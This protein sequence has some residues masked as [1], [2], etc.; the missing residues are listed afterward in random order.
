MSKVWENFASDF[1]L[2]ESKKLLFSQ[3][4]EITPKLLIKTAAA[5]L[6]HTDQWD[7]QIEFNIYFYLI[8]EQ[9][10]LCYY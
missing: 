2:E 8:T 3:Q 1:S 10:Y 6:Q 7:W 4:I 5:S 9:I